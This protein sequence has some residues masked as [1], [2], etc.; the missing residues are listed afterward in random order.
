VRQKAEVKMMYL[1]I[2]MKKAME[3]T[4]PVLLA[5]PSARPRVVLSCL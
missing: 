2:M 1:M 4:K 3:M 5:A